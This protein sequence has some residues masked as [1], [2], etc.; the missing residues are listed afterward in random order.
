MDVNQ[1]LGAELVGQF[2]L[3]FFLNKLG[4]LFVRSWPDLLAFV[5]SY[6]FPLN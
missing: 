5:F 1:F 2:L 6:P 3:S 4:L